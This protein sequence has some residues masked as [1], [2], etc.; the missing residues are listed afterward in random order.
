MH[1]TTR[2]AVLARSA[3][4]GLL[5]GDAL[6]VPFEFKAAA[7]LK[8]LPVLQPPG[9][10]WG[11]PLT[12]ELNTGDVGYGFVRTH[13]GTPP[14]TWSD[15]GATALA[16]LDALLTTGGRLDLDGLGARLVDWNR[17]GAYTPDGRVFDI[18]IQTSRAIAAIEAGRRLDP[19]EQAL[20]NG[21]VMRVLPLA[22]VHKGTDA[23]L[24]AAAVEQAH[25]THPSRIAGYG[26]A[27]VA[28]WAWQGVHEGDGDH[29]PPLRRLAGLLGKDVWSLATGIANGRGRTQ[30]TLATVVAAIRNAADLPITARWEETVR[31]C[32]VA[33]DDTDT[34]AAIAGGIAG[35]LGWPVPGRLIRGLQGWEVLAPY[36]LGLE[37]WLNGRVVP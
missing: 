24:V 35:A 36:M 32:I 12:F 11:C 15:D 5:V 10:A 30:D 22:L 29:R 25:L 2:P 16:L 1:D 3:M 4:L 23:E 21:A 17:R 14:G 28:L 20:G 8:H 9:S 37:A 27:L 31:R 33:G 7:V 19:D 26:A 13:A 34:T 18:G 6:G